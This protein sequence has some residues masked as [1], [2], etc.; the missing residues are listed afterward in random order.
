MPPGFSG[1][2]LADHTILINLLTGLREKV[3]SSPP[4][5]LK[6]SVAAFLQAMEDCYDSH[7]MICEAFVDNGPSLRDIQNIK[8]DPPPAIKTLD[9]FKKKRKKM[10]SEN[11]K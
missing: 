4:D 9:Q 1:V 7:N 5:P 10:L 2:M 3:F 8:K 11:K 6:E